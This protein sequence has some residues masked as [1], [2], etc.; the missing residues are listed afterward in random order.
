MALC[1]IVNIHCIQFKYHE[2]SNKISQKKLHQEGLAESLRKL[3][4]TE[5]L[6]S[7]QVGK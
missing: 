5:W 6:V 1:M 3:G 4:A 2:R 7:W